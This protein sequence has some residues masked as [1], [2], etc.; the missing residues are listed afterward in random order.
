MYCGY[1]N[2]ACSGVLAAWLFVWLMYCRHSGA[3]RNRDTGWLYVWLMYFRYTGTGW[4]SVSLVYFRYTGAA[5]KGS[6]DVHF[7]CF[8][9]NM[10]CERSASLKLCAFG[11]LE[12]SVG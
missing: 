3:A 9:R 8:A 6:T 5:R 7:G 12:L 10:N 11:I 2:A 4:L 1:A